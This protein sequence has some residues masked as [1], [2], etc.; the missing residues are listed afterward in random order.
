[1]AGVSFF[2]R[3]WLNYCFSNP[4]SLYQYTIY[5]IAEGNSGIQW[6][7][8]NV[9]RQVCCVLYFNFIFSVIN[10][11]TD[12]CHNDFLDSFFLFSISKIFQAFD[13][14]RMASFENNKYS[15]ININGSWYDPF[16]NLW[17]LSFD[18]FVEDVLKH[19]HLQ[20]RKVK[21]KLDI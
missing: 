21:N 10:C 14:K 12:A 7:S 2:S 6:R 3:P 17:I 18:H 19:L 9:Q 13:V 5:C 1:M 16:F 11:G 8:R 4:W 15:R 20:D